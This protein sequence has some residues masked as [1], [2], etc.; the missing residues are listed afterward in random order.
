MFLSAKGTK[1]GKESFFPSSE[2]LFP[3]AVGVIFFLCEVSQGFF[4]DFFTPS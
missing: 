2:L 4:T 3:E 1:N